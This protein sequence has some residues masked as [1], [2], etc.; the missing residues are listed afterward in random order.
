[1]FLSLKRKNG[2]GG[3]FMKTVQGKNEGGANQD[4]KRLQKY[5]KPNAMCGHQVDSN[6]NKQL[7][8]F[9]K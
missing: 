9:F 8:Q 7:Q 5:L 6:S 4:Y 3:T 1:M 2:G